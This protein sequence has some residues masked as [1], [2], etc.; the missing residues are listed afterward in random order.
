M[1][2]KMTLS[3]Y[4]LTSLLHNILLL[5]SNN[6]KVNLSNPFNTASILSLQL[7]EAGHNMIQLLL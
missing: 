6:N 5:E 7:K 2:F 3:E 1:L 4:Y